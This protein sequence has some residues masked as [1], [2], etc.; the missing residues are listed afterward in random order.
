MRVHC[1]YLPRSY[2]TS[3]DIHR[4]GYMHVSLKF[5]ATAS[6]NNQEIRNYHF[7]SDHCQLSYCCHWLCAIKPY[8]KGYSHTMVL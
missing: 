2:T 7:S 1:L 5:H 4:C 8:F 6:D 3:P